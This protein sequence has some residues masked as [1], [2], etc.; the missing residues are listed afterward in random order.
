MSLPKID[1]MKRIKIFVGYTL[2]FNAY[3]A[4]ELG[5]YNVSLIFILIFVYL[6]S[7]LLG[8]YVFYYWLK[9]RNMLDD[10]VIALLEGN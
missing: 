5:K 6:C 10:Y 7:L 3:L 9:E 8:L 2:F 4:W 1:L